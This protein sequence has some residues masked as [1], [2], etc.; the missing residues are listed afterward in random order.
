MQFSRGS[1]F[2]KYLRSLSQS[3]RTSDRTLTNLTTELQDQVVK[4]FNREISNVVEQQ[5][6]NGQQQKEVGC[7]NHKNI[8][9]SL[10]EFVIELRLE[11]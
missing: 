9:E 4:N 7:Y 2:S 5:E 6:F 11:T 10:L 8:S 3:G 1:N